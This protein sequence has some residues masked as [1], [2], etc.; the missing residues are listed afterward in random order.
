MK[1]K[2]SVA[3]VIV[4]Y[5]TSELLINLLDSLWLMKTDTNYSVIIIDNDSSI[6]DIKT[7]KK[8]FLSKCNHTRSGSLEVAEFKLKISCYERESNKNKIYFIKSS[9]NGGFASGCNIGASV[10]VS[11]KEFEYIWFLN[12]D[13][14]V[15]SYSLESIMLKFSSN[16]NYSAVGCR[17]IDYYNHNV[18]GVCG[19]GSY[20]KIFGLP[21]NISDKTLVN[22][23]K[24]I[25][26]RLLYLH[27]ASMMIKTEMIIKYSGFCESYF[28]YFEE[29]D[30]FSRFNS[31]ELLGYA[32]NSFVYH[33]GAASSSSVA[34][35]TDKKGYLSEFSEYYMF[36]NRILFCR[37]HYPNML[38]FVL[39]GILYALIKRL[40]LGRF[41]SAKTILRAMQ[42]SIEKLPSKKTL[43][44]DIYAELSWHKAKKVTKSLTR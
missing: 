11:L 43:F 22:D 33:V 24:I 37:Y 44:F 7:L 3:V 26:D 31:F 5:N 12:P 35:S 18:L 42:D 23:E 29:L 40:L 27:G 30:F 41:I 38:M 9:S 2:A 4:N 6:G 1:K 20:C 32:S 19:G 39:V 21:I 25:E 8:Y 14:Y 16:K 10:A 15:D 34:S 28:H 36:K 13:T 17:I